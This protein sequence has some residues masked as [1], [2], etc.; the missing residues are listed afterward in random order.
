MHTLDN[1]QKRYEASQAENN[2]LRKIIERKSNEQKFMA[3]SPYSNTP[4]EQVSKPYKVTFKDTSDNEAV[5]VTSPEVSSPDTMSQTQLPP[6]EKILDSDNDNDSKATQDK[7]SEYDSV[8]NTPDSEGSS[9]P[10]KTDVSVTSSAGKQVTSRYTDSVKN[11]KTAL[12]LDCKLI[13][14]FIYYLLL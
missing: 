8:Q 1:L 3:K 10:V 6:D 14:L 9:L 2:Q 5:S 4:D 11:Y 12:K 13:P 7:D